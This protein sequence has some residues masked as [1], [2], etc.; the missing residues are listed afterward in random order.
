[1]TNDIINKSQA[2]SSGFKELYDAHR[3]S[4]DS[5]CTAC[6]KNWLVWQWCDQPPASPQSRILEW[7]VNKLTSVLLITVF[8]LQS[9]DREIK[10]IFGV[11]PPAFLIWAIS[12]HGITSWLFRCRWWNSMGPLQNV[13]DL[14]LTSSQYTGKYLRGC[15]VFGKSHLNF[16][17]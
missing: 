2:A 14:N 17:D 13:L 9:V 6:H 3:S 11:L 7:T 5:S 4:I 10:S 15:Y 1:M 8:Y 16:M 12:I